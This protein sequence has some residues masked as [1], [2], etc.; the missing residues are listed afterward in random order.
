MGIDQRVIAHLSKPI[1]NPMPNIVMVN[2]FGR[3]GLTNVAADTS[4]VSIEV[5]RVKFRAATRMDGK[6]L[7]FSFGD[8]DA[9]VTE[10]EW[11]PEGEIPLCMMLHIMHTLNRDSSIYACAKMWFLARDNKAFWRLPL[12]NIFEDC[13]VCEGRRAKNFKTMMECVVDALDAFDKNTWNA[14]LL[15]EDRIKEC[16]KLF[17]FKPDKEGTGFKWCGVPEGTKWQDWC[18]KIG[19][20]VTQY[21]AL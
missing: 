14:D 8:H 5:T 16:G 21:L 11:R 13:G 19:V 4:Y 20:N 3:M 1:V 9:P 2:S 6:E 10:I 12:P 15:Y 17:R 7:V 18:Q